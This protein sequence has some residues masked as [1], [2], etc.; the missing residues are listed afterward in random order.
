MTEEENLLG[1]L[2][3]GTLLTVCLPRMFSLEPGC[4]VQ[5]LLGDSGLAM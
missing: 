5:S 1:S 4:L 2:C 3:S